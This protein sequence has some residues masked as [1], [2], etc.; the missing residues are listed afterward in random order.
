VLAL[1]GADD[2]QVSSKE[3]LCAISLA[4]SEGQNKCFKVLELPA[5]NHMFQSD[6]SGGQKSYGEIEE[7]ISYSVLKIIADWILSLERKK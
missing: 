7:T 2:R 1:N 6:N 4:L 3:N 5:F